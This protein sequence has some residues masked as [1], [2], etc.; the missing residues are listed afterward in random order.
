MDVRNKRGADISSDHHL[1]VADFRL[2]IMATG[3]RFEQ[4]N[5]RY[6]VKQLRTSAKK[7]E[8]HLELKKTAMKHFKK[9]RKPILKVHGLRLRIST[10]A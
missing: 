2:K 8:F 7:E 6:Y 3:R 4:R 5:Q 9:Q 10:A 1:V